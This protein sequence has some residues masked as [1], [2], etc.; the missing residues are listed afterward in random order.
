MPKIASIL[1]H[2]NTFAPSVDSDTIR[3][4]FLS[5][6]ATA[7][8]LAGEFDPDAP[9]QSSGNKQ[10]L[11]KEK[12]TVVYVSDQSNYYILDD[13]SNSDIAPEASGSGWITLLSA[14]GGQASSSIVADAHSGI[15]AASSSDN[16]GLTYIQDLTIDSNGHVTGIGTNTIT[17][18]DLDIDHLITLSGVAAA[19]DDLGTFTGSTLTDNITIKAALQELETAVEGAT[20]TALSGLTDTDIATPAGG[21]I[22]V[23]DGTDSFDNVAVSGDITI[24]STGEAAIASG[25]IVNDDI[26]AGAAIATSKLASN[27]ISGV[28]LGGTLGALTAAANGGISVSSYTG[29]SAVNDLQLDIDGMTDIGAAIV[30]ADLFIVDDGAGGANRK[31]EA[32]RIKTYVIAGITNADAHDGITGATDVDESG[33]TFIQDITMDAYGHVTALGTSTVTQA[34]LNIDDLITLT[35]VADGATNLGG[36]TGTVLSSSTL[37][38]KA[39]L[40][41]LG[42]QVDTN[43]NNTGSTDLSQNTAAGSLEVVSSTGNNVTLQNASASLAGIITAQAQTIAG[44]KTFNDDVTI[45]GNLTVTGAASYVNIQEEN[46]YIKDALITLGITDADASSVADGT[47]A[48]SD[49]GLEAYKQGHD[50]S[51]SPTLTYD[52]SADYWTVHNKDH[53]DS[54][55]NKIAEKYTVTASAVG[56]SFVVTHNLN[57]TDVIVQA[58][59]AADDEIV[60]VKY[61]CNSTQQTTIYF[62][63]GAQ[64]LNIKIV[65]IG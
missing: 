29:T 44:N 52:I 16:N 42:T 56:A 49:V 12:G 9:L 23:Y 31:T 3:G 47:A 22:L 64:G 33:L 28:A 2:T 4:G 60:Y 57:T 11:I 40:Q 26:A 35:G 41:A 1:S 39:A 54:T 20:G 13:K 5:V 55:Q 27:T 24:D 19:S 6:R 32:S 25:V 15:S 58:R 46:V 21:H 43:S 65:I 63:S 14:I 36:F 18:A 62:G 50:G 59:N 38:I 51:V 37:T 7:S 17:K 61:I 10:D 8:G 45:A 30:D 48:A 34:S 53:A